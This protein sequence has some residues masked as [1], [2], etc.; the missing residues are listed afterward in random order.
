MEEFLL[1]VN[2][3]HSGNTLAME[4]KTSVNFIKKLINF[5]FIILS[6]VI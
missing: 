4:L 3:A 6:S 5:Y 1:K 2:R